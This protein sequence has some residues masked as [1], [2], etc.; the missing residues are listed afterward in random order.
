MLAGIHSCI[1]WRIENHSCIRDLA[2]AIFGR[3]LLCCRARDRSEGDHVGVCQGGNVG[4]GP[5]FQ[6][7]VFWPVL[8]LA[9]MLTASQPGVPGRDALHTYMSASPAP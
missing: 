5:G 4:H 2:D 1:A 3:I 7:E 6:S 9:P 8:D